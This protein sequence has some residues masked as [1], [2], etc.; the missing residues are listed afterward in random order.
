M[1]N[2]LS[3]LDTIKIMKT[4]IVYFNGIEVGEIKAGNHNSAEKKAKAKADK[5]NASNPPGIPKIK[6][7][8]IVYT[9]V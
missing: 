8:S 3:L 7:V 4:F 2:G 1:P 9:E 6:D 5:C